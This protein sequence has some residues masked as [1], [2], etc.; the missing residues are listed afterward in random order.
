MLLG[1]AFPFLPSLLFIMQFVCVPI[2]CKYSGC[3]GSFRAEVAT[4]LIGIGGIYPGCVVT[5]RSL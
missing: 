5:Y 3:W 4:A 2:F 1:E